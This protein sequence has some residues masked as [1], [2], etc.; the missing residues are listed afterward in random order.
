MAESN[1]RQRQKR[2]VEEWHVHLNKVLAYIRTQEKPP[3]EYVGGLE[4]AIVHVIGEGQPGLMASIRERITAAQRVVQDGQI[5]AHDWHYLVDTTPMTLDEVKDADEK[6]KQKRRLENAAAKQRRAARADQPPTPPQPRR[7][8]TQEDGL[9]GTKRAIVERTLTAHAMARFLRALA[10]PTG[11][12]LD[13]WIMALL[14]NCDDL[15]RADLLA[16]AAEYMERNPLEELSDR[17]HLEAKADRVDEQ[18]RIIAEQEQ[19]NGELQE[20]IVRMR[21]ELSEIDR[22]STELGESR[23][24]I[25][26]LLDPQSSEMVQMAI[27]HDRARRA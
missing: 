4:R 19:R 11:S 15:T 7:F 27:R 9:V 23:R 24:L 13:D 12:D 18:A 20:Q 8:H 3:G 1:Q 10:K 22:L 2:T 26:L 21:Q 6:V 17:A 16:E 25:D 14:P 5:G